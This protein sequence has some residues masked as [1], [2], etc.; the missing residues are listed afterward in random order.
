MPPQVN[1]LRGFQMDLAGTG[2]HWG[3]GRTGF[4]SPAAALGQGPAPSSTQA[5]FVE[6]LVP[7]LTLSS[8]HSVL[9]TLP[10]LGAVS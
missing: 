6:V 9:G 1:T 4:P 8:G 5:S 7:T 2:R 3:P 10:A